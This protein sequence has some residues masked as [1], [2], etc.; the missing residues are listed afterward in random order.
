MTKPIKA[1]TKALF[2]AMVTL[3]MFVSGSW[4]GKSPSTNYQEFAGCP[5]SGSG[6]EISVLTVC[7]KRSREVCKSIQ[8]AIEEI[9]SLPDGQREMNSVGNTCYVGGKCSVFTREL[10][11]AERLEN[12][13]N[14]NASSEVTIASD[15]STDLSYGQTQLKDCLA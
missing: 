15:N 7:W 13:I 8:S 12:P 10:T 1:L 9:N 2:S 5:S 3:A 6:S 14:G 11:E 4:A